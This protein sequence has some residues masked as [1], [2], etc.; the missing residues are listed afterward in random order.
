MRKIVGWLGILGLCAASTIWATGCARKSSQEDKWPSQ[1]EE[2]QAKY[3]NRLAPPKYQLISD[4]GHLYLDYGGATFDV[5]EGSP[6][7]IR[8]EGFKDAI[9]VFDGKDEKARTSEG[10]P[11]ASVWS[12]RYQ[13]LYFVANVDNNGS[14][15]GIESDYGKNDRCR[16]YSWDIKN[17]L[18]LRLD[19]NGQM[20]AQ[21]GSPRE[22]RISADGEDLAFELQKYVKPGQA[23]KIEIVVMSLAN[24]VV[25]RYPISAEQFGR[26]NMDNTSVIDS[27]TLLIAGEKPKLLDLKTSQTKAISVQ[28]GLFPMINF[29]GQMWAL[30]FM[31]GKYDIV[32]VNSTFDKIEQ[33]VEIPAKFPRPIRPPDYEDG[34][35]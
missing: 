34:G 12:D 4:G 8:V 10:Y 29:Q 28:G 32:R 31:N 11:V 2:T 24:Q 25:T 19:W 35:D 30:R 7:P 16:L 13:A 17:G 3:S 14:R 9:V 20:I 6:N 33:I 21:D 22:L 23:N 27:H 1:A 26:F 5:V 15:T 18:K